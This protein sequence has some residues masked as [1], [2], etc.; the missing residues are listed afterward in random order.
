LDRGRLLLSVAEDQWFDRK[1][2]RV[3]SRD[4]AN[5]LIG[6]A[7]AEGGLI[8]IWLHRRGVVEDPFD[9]VGELV[10]IAGRSRPSVLRALEALR[11]AGVGEWVG[12]SRKDP[13]AYWRLPT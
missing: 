6:L 9:G 3:S 8:A 4:L 10:R 13:R 12:K 1:S 11:D 7:N 2:G 5:T